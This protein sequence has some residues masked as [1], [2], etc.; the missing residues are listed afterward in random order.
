MSEVNT[1]DFLGVLLDSN[2]PWKTHI[3]KICNKISS[4][5]LIINR[6]S[7]II[8]LVAMKTAYYESVHGFHTELVYGDTKLNI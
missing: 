8:E 1:A 5:L 2:L 3:D 4:S 7:K 6:M